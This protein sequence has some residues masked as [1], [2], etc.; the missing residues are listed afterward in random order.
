MGL[1]SAGFF[2]LPIL[3]AIITMALCN[4]TMETQFIA[5]TT[6]FISGMILTSL[7]AKILPR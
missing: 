5:G 7:F 2:L 3:I 1:I 6:G 4:K